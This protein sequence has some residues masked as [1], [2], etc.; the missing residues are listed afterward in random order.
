ME[1]SE[2]I[3]CEPQNKNITNEIESSTSVNNEQLFTGMVC[4]ELLKYLH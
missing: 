3:S 4:F 1:K 2:V